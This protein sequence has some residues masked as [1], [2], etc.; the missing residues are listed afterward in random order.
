MSLLLLDHNKGFLRLKL[1]ASSGD[2]PCSDRS[3]K[4]RLA[5]QD[6]KY[7]NGASTVLRR[8]AAVV[9]TARVRPSGAELLY[10]VQIAAGR[11]IPAVRR[12]EKRGVP[13]PVL[14][15]QRSLRVT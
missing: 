10:G 9:R 12:E 6:P 15:G 3:K 2:F 13:V 14:Q 8:L 1:W 7:R 4:R 11:R 5:V